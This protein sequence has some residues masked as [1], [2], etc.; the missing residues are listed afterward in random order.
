MGERKRNESEE[1]DAEKL[2]CV[3]RENEVQNA[4]QKFPVLPPVV[5]FLFSMVSTGKARYSP[6]SSTDPA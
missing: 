5:R 3:E 6:R 1:G 4:E 2:H